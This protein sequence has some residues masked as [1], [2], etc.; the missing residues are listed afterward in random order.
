MRPTGVATSTT[1]ARGH[2]KPCYASGAGNREW[3]EYTGRLSYVQ[4]QEARARVSGLIRSAFK[5]RG[6]RK[7]D[8]VF[9]I[10][11]RPF[12]AELDSKIAGVASAKAQL[13]KAASDLRRI[14]EAI[15]SSAVSQ[16]DRDAP[17]KAAFDNATARLAHFPAQAAVDTAKLDVTNGAMSPPEIDGRISDKRVSPRKSHHRR[18]RAGDAADDRHLAR[19]HLLRCRR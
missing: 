17:L 11:V 7:S 16:S 15:K 9:V 18:R 10:D 12:K 4:R 2:G 13:E 14:D 1:A 3:D 5:E 19:S 8:E 6:V